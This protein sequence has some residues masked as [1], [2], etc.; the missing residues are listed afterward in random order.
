MPGNS[1]FLGWNYTTS[2][3]NTV[4]KVHGMTSKQNFPCSINEH[5]FLPIE[6]RW[7]RYTASIAYIF[8]LV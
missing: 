1:I 4:M 6:L 5:I 7:V 2:L 3:F 8:S